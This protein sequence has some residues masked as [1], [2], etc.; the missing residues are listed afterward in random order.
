MP[1]E[2]QGLCERERKRA[3]EPVTG[4]HARLQRA[5]A[6]R[7]A[8]EA[9]RPVGSAAFEVA[10]VGPQRVE[11]YERKG[12]VQIRRGLF[13]AL[14]IR[15]G[16]FFTDRRSASVRA[17]GLGIGRAGAGRSE[18][19]SISD[20]YPAPHRSVWL[21]PRLAHAALS[22]SGARAGP[23]VGG[24]STGAATTGPSTRSV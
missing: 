10:G 11:I 2:P 8:R 23:D 7:L 17:C 20:R 22:A 15:L 12:W 1:R 14:E 24:A 21:G 18:I 3:G 16:A 13:E 9:D 4:E 19:P 5:A 6:Q